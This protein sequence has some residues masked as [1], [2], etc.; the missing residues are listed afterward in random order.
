MIKKTITYEDYNG[1]ERTEDFYFN[2]SKSEIINWQ[3]GVA[4][5][6]TE[7]ITKIVNAKDTPELIEYF[8]ELILKS[9]G[10]KSADGKQFVKSDALSDAFKQTP[11]YDI[12]YMELITDEN[13]AAEFVKGVLPKDVAKL[14]EEE[15]KANGG[16]ANAL[17]EGK[18]S[19]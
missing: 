19:N 7:L 18:P 17:L 9:Y 5:G 2:L 12:L 6:L 8:Q 4:G 14:I 3:L 15:E 1:L 11:A 13:V 10:E 16:M